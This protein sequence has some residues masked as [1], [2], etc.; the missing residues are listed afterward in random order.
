MPSRDYLLAGSVRQYYRNF[1]DVPLPVIEGVEL[2]KCIKQEGWCVGDNGIVL[3]CLRMG[4]RHPRYPRFKNEWTALTNRSKVS[5]Y[6]HLSYRHK[7]DESHQDV[8]IHVLVLENFV[9]PSPFL[10]AKARHKDDNKS[11]NNLSNLEWGTNR[12][13]M[14]DAKKNGKIKVGDNHLQSKI[15]GSMVTE[16][17]KLVKSGMKITRIYDMF[18][19]KFGLDMTKGGFYQA[20]RGKSWRHLEE[21]PETHLKAKLTDE[22]VMEIRRLGLEGFS[23][24]E[25]HSS[26]F[27]NFGVSVTLECVRH[28]L[29]G[30][31]WKYLD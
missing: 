18:V 28:A 6:P 2:R 25:I 24:P 1:A 9:G 23:C 5:G 13:N 8:F 11:N 31:T 17:R 12:E 22:H 19:D 21:Q 27:E 29:N 26:L 20:V 3:S 15:T 7:D 16:A 14:D 10:G 30:R 4:P